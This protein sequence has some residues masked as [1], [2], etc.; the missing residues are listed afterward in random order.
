MPYLVGWRE[1]C[2]ALP[3]ETMN[4]GLPTI[5]NKLPPLFLVCLKCTL[6][7]TAAWL[8]GGDHLPGLRHASFVLCCCSQEYYANTGALKRAAQN[9][10]GGRPVG[11]SI[12]EAFGG[13]QP[14]PKELEDVLRL[15]Y[16]TKLLNPK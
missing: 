1:C 7:A 5:V 11:C 16:R 14:V 15:E 6:Y 8:H 9:A 13:E 12:V 4:E 3:S 2:V 10:R